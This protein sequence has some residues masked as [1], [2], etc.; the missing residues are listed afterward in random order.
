MVNQLPCSCCEDYHTVDIYLVLAHQ[1]AE[2]LQAVTRIDLVHFGWA[3]ES[4]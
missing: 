3:V 4:L 2:P 1:L